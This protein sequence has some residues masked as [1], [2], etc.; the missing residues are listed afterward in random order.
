MQVGERFNPGTMSIPNA[1]CKY[2]GLSPGAKL[3]WG[4]LVQCTGKDGR[5]SPEQ[6]TLAEKLGMSVSQTKRYI[7]E[8]IREHFL[9]AER[10]PDCVSRK[11]RPLHLTNSY[12]FLFHEIFVSETPSSDNPA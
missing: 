8:L 3:C 12:V 9:K 10:S 2:K 4:R 5:C 11:G 6:E 7:S 1:L